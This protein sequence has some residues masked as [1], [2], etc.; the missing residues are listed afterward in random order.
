MMSVKPSPLDR[1]PRAPR[2]TRAPDLVQLVHM[3]RG[4]MRANGIKGHK[5]EITFRLVIPGE[6][7]E[8]EWETCM[9]NQDQ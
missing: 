9:P 8:G 2:A 7:Q 5:G 4:P 1:A 6:G 3:R